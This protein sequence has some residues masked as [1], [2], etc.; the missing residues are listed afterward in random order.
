MEVGRRLTENEG[1]KKREITKNDM[2]RK[3][4][5]IGEKPLYREWNLVRVLFVAILSF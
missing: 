5:F 3:F 2:G 1:G 4:S